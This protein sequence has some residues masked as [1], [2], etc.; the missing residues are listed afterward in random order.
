[1]LLVVGFE[2]P[3][4]V[5]PPHLVVA[6]NGFVCAVVAWRVLSLSHFVL[7]MVEHIFSL[8]LSLF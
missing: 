3:D 5:L 2:P 7:V 6:M 8:Y 4:W 1:V